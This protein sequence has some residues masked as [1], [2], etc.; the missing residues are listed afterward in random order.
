MRKKILNRNLKFLILILLLSISLILLTQNSK[1]LIVDD[2][3]TE[4]TIYVSDGVPRVDAFELRELDCDSDGC[5]HEV[6]ESSEDGAKF[7]PIRSLVNDYIQDE[8]GENAAPD[9]CLRDYSDFGCI[10]FSSEPD[11]LGDD[12]IAKLIFPSGYSFKKRSQGNER[13]DDSIKVYGTN[14]CNEGDKNDGWRLFR[15]SQVILHFMQTGAPVCAPTTLDDMTNGRTHRWFGCKNEGDLLIYL[16]RNSHYPNG[17]IFVARCMHKDGNYY[18]SFSNGDWKE[19]NPAPS[20]CYNIYVK[21]T[22][23][24]AEC[25]TDGGGVNIND[26]DSSKLGSLIDN[27]IDKNEVNDYCRNLF[28]EGYYCGFRKEGQSIEECNDGIDNDGDGYIDMEDVDCIKLA[29]DFG[30]DTVRSEDNTKYPFENVF[31][32]PSAREHFNPNTF[33]DAVC[34]DDGLNDY[35][36]IVGSYLCN[37]SDE[38]WN[39]LKAFQ[40]AP[41]T[42]INL[43]NT[44]FASNGNN[45]SACMNPK[46]GDSSLEKGEI[47][48]PMGGNGNNCPNVDG[49]SLSS[50]DGNICNCQY[51]DSNNNQYS[52]GNCGD[53]GLDEGYQNFCDAL[54]ASMNGFGAML[55]EQCTDS[56]YNYNSRSSSSNTGEGYMDFDDCNGL[57]VEDC[58]DE[59][60]ACSNVCDDNELCNG[61]SF[62]LD[63]GQICCDGECI[64]ENEDNCNGYAY[65]CEANEY[66]PVDFRCNNDRNECKIPCISSPLDPSSLVCYERQKQGMFAECGEN[67]FVNDLPKYVNLFNRGESLFTIDGKNNGGKPSVLKINIPSYVVIDNQFVPTDVLGF[68]FASNIDP[69]NITVILKGRHD[70]VIASYRLSDLTPIPSSKRWHQALIH[71]NNIVYVH[72]INFDTSINNAELMIDNIRYTSTNKISPLMYCSGMYREWINTLDPS[73]NVEDKSVYAYACNGIASYGWTGTQCCGN[74][75]SFTNSWDLEYYNDTNAGCFASMIVPNDYT[76]SEALNVPFFKDLLF[77]NGSYW[78]CN[79]S[80]QETMNTEGRKISRLRLT[81]ITGRMVT[82]TDNAGFDNDFDAGFIDEPDVP[83]TPSSNNEADSKEININVSSAYNYIDYE[84][85]PSFTIKGNH[86]CGIDNEWH[87]LKDLPFQQIVSSLMYDELINNDKGLIICGG[88]ELINYNYSLLDKGLLGNIT[89]ICIGETFNN[90]E[91]ERVIVAVKLN[92][93][94]LSEFINT[95]YPF[96]NDK[97]DLTDFINSAP[98]NPSNQ[99]F[100]TTDSWNIDN[101]KLIIS[102]N[103]PANIAIIE[104]S[105]NNYNGF[106]GFFKSIID[107]IIN[108]FRPTLSYSPLIINNDLFTYNYS[109]YSWNSDLYFKALMTN[110]QL[111]LETNM[112]KGFSQLCP[113]KTIINDP[114]INKWK[115]IVKTSLIFTTPCQQ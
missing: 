66:C 46:Y 49:Y 12:D 88:Q 107:K 7:F 8:D 86:Y 5:S 114:S 9:S 91:I 84:Q 57:D 32:D 80:L 60:Q 109:L 82:D 31:T 56:S 110:Q 75:Q 90:D 37:G 51:R 94:N 47:L 6:W 85:V 3:T 29:N 43:T 76:V 87:S 77:F 63:N 67:Y 44:F 58:F 102:Y 50:G 72:S 11:F 22:N 83:H 89:S 52:I 71:F 97:I 70:S 65:Y 40:Q 95:F 111:I 92:D 35:K 26:I 39:I 103:K 62:A 93:Y 17:A 79:S 1:A 74:N 98:M 27:S 59:S 38:S 10:F 14:D 34:G 24:F 25:L 18:W 108:L 54:A 48:S 55:I 106:L 13:R 69:H 115:S 96:T 112:E 81:G 30:Y 21:G 61:D 100:F 73:P 41:G 101:F 68:D 104:L 78:R 28:G 53:T 36:E 64:E 16:L 2:L 4:H 19:V 15:A 42:I 33:R 45:W 20:P 99:K 113:E 105:T 23:I